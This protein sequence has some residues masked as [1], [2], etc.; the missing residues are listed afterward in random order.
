MKTTKKGGKGGTKCK[1]VICKYKVKGD[2]MPTP[3]AKRPN[4]TT[5][6]N[7]SSSMPSTDMQKTM[8]KNMSSNK[9]GS[10]MGGSN[11]AKKSSGGGGCKTCGGR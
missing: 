2:G 3:N 4:P 6:T 1:S 7:K 8:Q 10:S 11:P 9:N 5:N